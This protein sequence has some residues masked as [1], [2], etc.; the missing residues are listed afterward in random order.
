LHRSAGRFRRVISEAAGSNSWWRCEDVS[1]RLMIGKMFRFD[2]IA[3]PTLRKS[4]CDG[5][6]QACPTAKGFLMCSR[7]RLR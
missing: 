6:A 4:E 1:R 3:L 2:V 7:S 5:D